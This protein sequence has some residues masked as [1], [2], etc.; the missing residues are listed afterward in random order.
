MANL[1]KIIVKAQ[2]I[3]EEAAIRAETAKTALSED[4]MK[5][6][7]RA[8]WHHDHIP[9]T[10]LPD[11]V[12]TFKLTYVTFYGNNFIAQGVIWPYK[13]PAK[14]ANFLFMSSGRQ[15]HYNISDIM[16]RCSKDFKQQR[17]VYR[18]QKK[19]LREVEYPY[20]MEPVQ[21]VLID[22]EFTVKAHHYKDKL[23]L[24]FAPWRFQKDID[25]AEMDFR[26]K[27]TDPELIKIIKYI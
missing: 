24:D 22:E 20:W 17:E 11:G 2:Q 1:G 25:R 10:N 21:D 12:C 5:L 3:Q 27:A 15:A 7:Q 4:T 14:A 23:Q 8:R 6:I 16:E 18:I 9:F 26:L 13:Q 19:M